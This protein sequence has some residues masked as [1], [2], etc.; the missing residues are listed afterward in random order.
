MG[1]PRILL[2]L[3]ALA[4]L[5]APT[6]TAHERYETD[7]G[8]VG[9]VLGEQDEPVYTYDW[10]NI[11]LSLSDAGSGEP[12]TGA[13]E[14]LE[15]TLIAPNGAEL[16]MPLVPQH[17]TEGRYA[18]EED[19]FLTIPGQYTA[20]LEGSIAGSPISGE[21]LLPGP[22]PDMKPHAFPTPV[23][24][25]L[26]DLAQENEELRAT[27]EDLEARI[28]ALE[29]GHVDGAVDKGAP[30][31]ALPALLALLGISFLVHRRRS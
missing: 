2:A 14:T 26:V 19:Y 11:D 20:R 23:S 16:S 25:D 30:G 17:G 8:E 3:L 31:P 5:L 15:L 4:L 13:E 12:I 29:S 6:A 7:D 10:T 18:F 28:E 22:R 1:N 21:Y 24:H 9:I 27:V